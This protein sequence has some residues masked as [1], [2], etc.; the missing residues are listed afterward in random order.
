MAGRNGAGRVPTYKNFNKSET[1][2]KPD[3]FGEFQPEPVKISIKT[4]WDGAGQVG[5]VF[6]HP[7]LEDCL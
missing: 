7:Y 5:R 3:G 1:R 2:T 4:V 6:A